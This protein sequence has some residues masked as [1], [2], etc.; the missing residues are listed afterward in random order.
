M[1][2]R[3]G[4]QRIGGTTAPCYLQTP[5]GSNRTLKKWR[6]GYLFLEMQESN[7]W[8]VDLSPTLR[9]ETFCLV[10]LRIKNFWM[11]WGQHRHHPG[12]WCREIPRP[13]DDFGQTE[14]NIREMDARRLELG[15]RAIYR[16]RRLTIM[17]TCIRSLSWEFREP[18]RTQVL[19]FMKPEIKIAVSVKS[20]T[21]KEPNGSIQRTKANN[22]VLKE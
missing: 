22:T 13:M 17:N 2:A 4:T 3:A 21:G 14:I 15:R 8:L 18:G 6:N 12:S 10:R 20:S 1:N 9:M 5:R 16:K 19:E 11:C 7:E